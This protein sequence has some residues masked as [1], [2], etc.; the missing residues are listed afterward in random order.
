VRKISKVDNSF[1]IK[2]AGNKFCTH[3][4]HNCRYALEFVGLSQIMYRLTLTGNPLPY[5]FFEELLNLPP[6]NSVG[7]WG[8]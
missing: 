2:V 6:C 8:P 4:E 1:K 7:I 3:F 5:A